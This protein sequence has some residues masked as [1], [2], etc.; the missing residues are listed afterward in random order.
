MDASVLAKSLGYI[1]HT[2]YY[3]FVPSRLT[4][5][6]KDKILIGQFAHESNTF[7]SE[8]TDREH[9]K[10]DREL[11]GE[12]VLAELT[13]TNSEIHGFASVLNDSPY[14][15]IPSIA[16]RTTPGG[17][18][19][20][21]TFEFYWDAIEQTLIEERDHIAGVALALHG[22]MVLE[23]YDDGDGLVLSRIREL[24]GEDVPIVATVDLHTNVTEEMTTN[25]DAIVA[26]EEY[27]HTD[28]YETGEAAAK[29][30]LECLKS[31]MDT[32]MHVE[33]PPLI[34]PGASQ[35]TSD[36]PMEGIMNRAR[37]L[38]E[39][40]GVLK[41]NVTPG[42][43]RA[44]IPEAG[45][46]VTT[47]ATTG[48]TAREVSRDVAEAIWDHRDDF[49]VEYPTPG[50]AV[51][52]AIDT[53]NSGDANA[54]PVVLADVGDNPGGGATGDETALLSELLD[55]GVEN[56]GVVLIHDPG[57]V[58]CCI[59]AGVGS[60]VTLDLGGKKVDTHTESIRN[61]EGYVK[62]VTDGT[63][64]NTGPMRTGTANDTGRTVLFQ[65]GEGVSVVV[66][67]KRIQPLDAELWRHVG[68]QPERLSIVVVKS[69]NH[70][71]AD[72][73]TLSDE[74]VPVDSP[75]INTVDPTDYDYENVS[76]SKVPLDEVK[77][78]PD[79]T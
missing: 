5:M 67:E 69:A 71:R 28:M 20:R 9:F 34:V 74:I 22:A 17:V 43:F 35:N 7:V 55:R 63:F 8:T 44:D 61:L 32:Y 24:L 21:E 59:D 3:L 10:V 13:G 16:A 4:N 2:K 57:A 78:Y 65:C 25:A 73:E 47:V 39:R 1:L 6:T 64:V 14:E 36:D 70:Y 29:I 66:T 41:V 15:T 23:D 48:D 76:R 54:T 42:F 68:V 27:P 79:W 45:F 56:A 18:V 26:Y 31:G 50:E 51:D 46:A 49:I 62:A 75:G 77:S 58:E 38:E 60:T 53:V 11:F 30:L 52:R 12:A 33:R 19:E 72:Y 37:E 40:S